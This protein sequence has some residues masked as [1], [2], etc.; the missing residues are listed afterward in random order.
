MGWALGEVMLRVAT[1]CLIFS[2]WTF[3][4][5]EK[6]SGFRVLEIIHLNKTGPHG[7]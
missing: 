5:D 3:S 4:C 1:L 6:L 2:F 7:K